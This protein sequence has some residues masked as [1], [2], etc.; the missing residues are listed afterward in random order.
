M[1]G[2]A[3]PF[4]EVAFRAVARP[5]LPVWHLHPLRCPVCQN[6]MR[7]MAVIDDPRVA[8]KIIRHLGA[9]H[10]PLPRPPPQGLP[11]PYTYEPCDDADPTPDYENLLTD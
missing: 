6:P 2:Q 10:D 9:W 5:S 11:G 8:E 7:V 3:R 1:R 4:P